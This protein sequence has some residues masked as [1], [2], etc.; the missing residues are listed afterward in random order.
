[1]CPGWA[2][3]G[4]CAANPG[5]MKVSCRLSCGECKPK[6]GSADKVIDV[7]PLKT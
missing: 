2:K 3:R 4:E 6:S 1:M 7:P 5:Y